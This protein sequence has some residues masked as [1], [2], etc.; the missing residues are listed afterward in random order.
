MS[1]NKANSTPSISA[2]DRWLP[3]TQCTRCGYPRCHAYATAV[4]HGE[5][6]INRCPPGGES[7]IAGLATLLQKPEMPL[8][9]ECG[10]YK[11]RVLALI[12]EPQ[13]IGCTLCIQVCP[14]DA[15]IGR[16]KRM[17]T[18]LTDLCTGCEL[19]LPACPVDCIDLV[20]D[21]IHHSDSE[22]RW[23][24]YSSLEVQ[25]ARKITLERLRRLARRKREREVAQKTKSK[26]D[27]QRI[28]NEI[29]AAVER[30]KQKRNGQ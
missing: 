23:P 5:A 21:N 12:I 4:A 17:H 26:S 7:T 8:D 22:S 2:I 1:G 15:I 27:S 9:P 28:R 25:R 11:P 10:E 20:P 30:V 14:V 6:N 24:D 18:V 29:R 13:C 3:Q 16:A 19:C